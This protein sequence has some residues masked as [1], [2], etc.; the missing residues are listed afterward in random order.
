MSSL[1]T[2]FWIVTGWF[3][4]SPANALA[5]HRNAAEILRTL[6]LD[7][8]TGVITVHYSPGRVERARVLQRSYGGAVMHYRNM[9]VGEPALDLTVTLAIL[10]PEHWSAITA[11]PYGLPNIDFTGWPHFVAV[12]PADND[13]GLTADYFR[14]RELTTQREVQRAVDVIGFHEFGHG[15]AVQYL[16]VLAPGLAD[17]TLRWFDEFMATYIGQGYLWHTE[18]MN[19][20]PIRPELVADVAPQYTTLSG[21]DEH[22]QELMTPEGFE[23]L[24]WYQ[25]QFAQRGREVFEKHGLEFIRRV[26][27]Q[28]P[29]DRYGNWSTEQLLAWLEEIEPGFVAWAA[30]LEA[31][32]GR[33][34]SGAF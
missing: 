21:F 13:R 1:V 25:V 30:G 3:L 32:D 8:L 9:F 7:S 23:T 28:L 16:Y 14:K 15:L 2:F 33:R 4:L 6:P 11:M 22:Y 24:G 31:K 34:S 29:W 27:N 12:L 26:R 10:N 20:D 19:A 5:Q 18:G 17:L